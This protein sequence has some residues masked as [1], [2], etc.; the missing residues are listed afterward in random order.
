MRT[1]GLLR[2]DCRKILPSETPSG[3]PAAG[4]RTVARIEVCGR[5]IRVGISLALEIQAS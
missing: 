3:D 4:A 5:Y 1:P 2:E